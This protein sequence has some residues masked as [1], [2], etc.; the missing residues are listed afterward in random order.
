MTDPRDLI[1]RLAD[2]LELWLEHCGPPSLPQEEDESFLLLREA[3]AYLAA[4]DEPAVPA[5]S[6]PTDEELA[7][8]YWKAWHEYHDRTNSVLH[9]AGLRAVL[10]RWG[11]R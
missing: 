6:E 7:N 1:Q 2:D 9:A 11:S 5:G 10:A 4:P 3:R 8:T